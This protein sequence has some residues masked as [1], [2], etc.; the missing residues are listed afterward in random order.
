MHPSTHSLSARLVE[1]VFGR[2]SGAASEKTYTV[3]LLVPTL[4]CYPK[5]MAETPWDNKQMM[6][7]LAL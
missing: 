3:R 7:A 2:F 5:P 4:S 1:R 6:E